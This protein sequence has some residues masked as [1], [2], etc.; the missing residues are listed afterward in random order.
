MVLEG[1]A[2]ELRKEGKGK[3]P[4]RAKSLTNEDEEKFWDC[5]EL[6]GSNPRALIQ[7]VWWNNCIHFGM[8]GREE[9]YDLKI[10]H[11]E[12]Q[13]DSQS[14]KYVSFKGTLAF[15]TLL[16]LRFHS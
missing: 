1:K 5:G 4:N 9:H 2:R 8:R 16:G 15:T 3:L 13:R 6:G 12:I 10:E 11:F 14:R 7:T